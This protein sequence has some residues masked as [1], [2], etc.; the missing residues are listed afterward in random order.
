MRTLP[1]NYNSLSV[2]VKACFLSE[3]ANASSRI[4]GGIYLRNNL[5]AYGRMFTLSNLVTK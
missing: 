2:V 3:F 4:P 1:A 5:F